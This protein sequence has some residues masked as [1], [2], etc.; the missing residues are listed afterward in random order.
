MDTI[1]PLDIAKRLHVKQNVTIRI[2]DEPTGKVVQ[3]HV[4]H[5]AATNSL[6][7]GIAHYLMGDGTLNQGGDILSMWVP[8]YISL[9]T[10][11]LTSQ[12]SETITVDGQQY[13]VPSALGSTPV[14]PASA[15]PTEKELN[16]QLRFTEYINQTPGFGAD[17]YDENTNN[18][19]EWFGLGYPYTMKPN[20]VTQDFY[21][22]GTNTFTL[23]DYLISAPKTE[24]FLGNGIA[25]EFTFI[26]GN[27]IQISSVVVSTGTVPNYTL[28]ISTNK[29]IFD[30]PPSNGATI[31]VVYLDVK[32]SIHS[33]TVYPEGVINEDFNDT[34]IRR[35]VL[36]ADDYTVTTPNTIVL[37]ET[38]PELAPSGSRVAIIYEISSKDAVNCELI[39][40]NISVN[41]GEITSLTL[42]SPITYRDT[43]PEYESE[44]PSTLD[45]VLSAFVSTGALKEFRGDNDYIY[46]T[47]AGLWSKSTYNASGDNGLLAGYRILPTDIADTGKE[48][49]FTGDGETTSFIFV[50]DIVTRIISVAVT[51]QTVTDDDY[52]L[53]ENLNA[54]K[55]LTFIPADGAVTTV[56]Y[57]TPYTQDSW[58][59]MT[60][61]A[62]RQKVQKT[63]LRIG[64]NQIAQIVWK[65]QLG[66]LE[67]LNGLRY[68]YPVQYPEEMWTIV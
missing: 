66:G 57:E 55:F 45:V 60:I 40:A 48:Q 2:I 20:K 21:D 6:L 52:I 59:D 46:I 47:E 32:S 30:T 15:T 37:R 5:N 63:I 18:N 23:T 16:T 8:Q 54:L 38:T 28:D 35:V 58:K 41:T 68:L 34:S 22:G 26:T 3:E 25:T 11:G 39:K 64:K 13:I 53:D 10:M 4:G 44:I 33:I 43:I 7:T 9:G 36:S 67:Q 49:Q 62:N 56:S 1:N 31:T 14:A 27:P 24:E 19:R 29:I 51:G 61:E 17:G 65:L 12:D 50:G 42:R